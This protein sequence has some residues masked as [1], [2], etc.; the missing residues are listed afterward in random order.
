MAIILKSEVSSSAKTP[1]IGQ[2]TIFLDSIS[3]NLYIKKPSGNLNLLASAGQIFETFTFDASNS[4]TD[5]VNIGTVY[6]N[7]GSLSISS[8]VYAGTSLGLS[9]VVVDLYKENDASLIT[10]WLIPSST[11]TETTLTNSA[12]LDATGWYSVRFRL[13]N[14]GGSDVALLKGLRLIFD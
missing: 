14:S 11:L 9:N 4:T 8:S 7:S 3:N 2:I 13:Q 10:S 6:L 12:S 1:Q 5:N